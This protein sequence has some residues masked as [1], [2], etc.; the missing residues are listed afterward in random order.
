M[1]RTLAATCVAVVLSAASTYAQ[2]DFI[3]PAAGNWKTWVIS[4]GKD[5]RVPPPPSDAS[6]TS[7]ELSQMRE[8][9]SH[10]DAGA[11][12][13]IRFWDAGSPGYQWIELVSS[14]IEEAKAPIPNAHRI[15]TYLTMAMYDA[16]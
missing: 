4:S 10:S 15:Y 5:F 11:A 14:R 7:L 6:A 13:Q 9:I 3:E 8:L 2:S 16:T 1:I 12:A